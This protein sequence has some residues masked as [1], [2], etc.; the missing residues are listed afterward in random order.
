MDDIYYYMF[1]FLTPKEIITC[2]K[3]NLSF[4]KSGRVH[5]IWKKFKDEYSE[6]FYKVNY[7][8]TYKI[9]FRLV[10]GLKWIQSFDELINL[11][12]LYLH[13]NQIVHIPKE[14]IQ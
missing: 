9:C 10:H 2:M 5:Y 7:Y 3:C 1:S 14:I 4:Y 8:E 11:Q 6:T 12:K 13:Y